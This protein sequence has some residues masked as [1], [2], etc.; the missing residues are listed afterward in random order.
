LVW[1]LEYSLELEY[2]WLFDF[3]L[4]VGGREV[5]YEPYLRTGLITARGL[6]LVLDKHPNTVIN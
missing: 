1:Y 2:N 5:G 6:F 3:S 4:G